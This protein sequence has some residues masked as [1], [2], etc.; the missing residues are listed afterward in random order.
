[1]KRN[2]GYAGTTFYG[3]PYFKPLT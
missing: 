3:F 2:E 1:M